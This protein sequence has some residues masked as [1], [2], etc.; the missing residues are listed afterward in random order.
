MSN[1][2]WHIGRKIIKESSAYKMIC[3]GKEEK[4][5]QGEIPRDLN[6]FI[7]CITYRGG[8]QYIYPV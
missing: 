2:N 1:D 5:K 4:E 8:S 7:N 3:R 6:D